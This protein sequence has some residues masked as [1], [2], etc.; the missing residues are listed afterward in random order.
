MGCD[1]ATDRYGDLKKIKQRALIVNGKDKGPARV[2]WM[3]PGKAPTQVR[4]VLG[5]GEKLSLVS[6]ELFWK[7]LAIVVPIIT[8]LI[9]AGATYASIPGPKP[10]PD[11]TPKAYTLRLHVY[12]I[13]N[14]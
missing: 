2:R 11:P 9:G 13:E 3:G 6:A 5:L 12:P 7:R 4:V 14:E 10:G 1:P 8:A